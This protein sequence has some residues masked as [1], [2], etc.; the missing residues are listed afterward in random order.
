MGRRILI[1]FVIIF[2]IF[3][4]V[5]GIGSILIRGYGDSP[6]PGAGK[7]IAVKIP[8]GS[9]PQ[10][11]AS[12]LAENQ[13]VEDA[14]DFYRWLRYIKR[15]AGKI[16]AGELAFRDNMTPNEVLQVLLDGTPVTIKI[17]VAEGLR[18]DE[19]ALIFADAGLSDAREFERLARN[20]RFVRSLGVPHNSMEGFLFPETYQFRKGSSLQKILQ[21]MFEAYQ[22][23]FQKQW[24]ERAKQLRMSE[25]E[26]VTLASIIEKETGAASE[27]PM[28]SGVFH[29][30]L[31]K[32]WKLQTDPTVIYAEILAKGRFDGTIHRSDLER[33]HPYNTY[34]R[35]GLPPGPICSAGAKAIEAALYPTKTK[36]MY[37]VSKNDGT[38]KFCPTLRCHNRAVARF[39]KRSAQ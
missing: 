2:A 7:N 15:A 8:K 26:V 37:F 36:N 28:I 12:L 23:N 4:V 25:L 20:A 21:T 13:V 32:R 34:R 38:H 14:K 3:G 27:R 22:K 33:E 24:R 39:Q 10:K 19:V 16:R 9:G 30:R 5:L 35:F 18:I 6:K 11:V 1:S 31:K 29:N 17:T